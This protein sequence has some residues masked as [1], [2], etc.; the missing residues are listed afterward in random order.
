MILIKNNNNDERVYKT[1]GRK[2]G[3][4]WFFK[5]VIIIIKEY[6]KEA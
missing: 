6:L 4:K 2:S 3:Y 1:E 5:R